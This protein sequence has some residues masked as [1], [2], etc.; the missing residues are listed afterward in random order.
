MKEAWYRSSNRN[1]Q[2]EYFDEHVSVRVYPKSGT[3]RI[4]PRRPLAFEELRVH[5]DDAFAKV[6]PS[7]ALLSDSFKRMIDGLQT[8]RRHRTFLVGP[9]TPFKIDFYR[10]SYG[11]SILADKSHPRHL[12][13]L[14]DWPAWIT[15]LFEAQRGHSFEIQNN[16]KVLA[17]FASQIKRH[18]HVMEGIGLAADRLN[19]AIHYLIQMIGKLNSSNDG[20]NDS[21]S[22][23]CSLE[24]EQRSPRIRMCQR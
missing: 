10:G 22:R 11:L 8:A 13:V 3:C 4:T 24:S 9:M 17:E 12:E 5:V 21:A 1:G 7:R 2:L 23:K 6:L 16:S 18:L 14:E 19:E 15:A 20:R